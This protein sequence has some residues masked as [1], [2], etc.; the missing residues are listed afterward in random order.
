MNLIL[1][2]DDHRDRF[3]PLSFTRPLSLFRLG[4]LTLAEKWELISGLNPSF[5]VPDYLSKVYCKIKTN[6]N[7]FLNSRLIPNKSIW[8]KI[9]LLA[10]GDS[11][12][13]NNILI[14]SRLLVWD[15]KLNPGGKKSK[16][17]VVK[18]AQNEIVDSDSTDGQ[19]MI[20]DETEFRLLNYLED[21]VRLNDEE[22]KKD[23][24]ILRENKT[25]GAISSTNRILGNDLW[26]NGKI[27]A[28]Y[29]T[30]NSLAGPIFIDEGVEIM[31]GAL[32]R[33]P[34]A[35]LKGSTVKMG[36]KIYG[37]TTIGPNCTV[38][39]EIKNSIL[40]AFSN[41]A[42]EGYLGDSIIGEWCN[43]GADTNNSNMKNNYKNVRLYDYTQHNFRETEMHFLGVI[44]G[45]HVKC[46]INS[47]LNTGTIMGVGVNWFGSALSPTFVPDFS[48]AESG[49][50]QEYRLDKMMD[51]AEKAMARRNVNL[52]ENQKSLLKSIFELTQKSRNF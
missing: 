11:I 31:E 51:T 6:D 29:V 22:I 41:K 14:A 39:G 24:E 10:I 43:L 16:E 26:V 50:I 15:Y 48:W 12:F 18:S 7:L 27:K 44:M 40:F 9:S 2:D 25:N 34:V 33:G 49:K 21:F 36:A 4:I 13:I 19:K 45:D 23:L 5:Q 17:I 28:E 42:H 8:K 47:T 46:G 32:I 1:F 37:G 20:L 52:T 3:L 35:L 38:G 30:L